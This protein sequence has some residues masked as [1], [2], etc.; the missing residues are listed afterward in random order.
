MTFWTTFFVSL[1][2]RF[3]RMSYLIL[4]TASQATVSQLLSLIDLRRTTEV[5]ISRLQEQARLTNL[6]VQQ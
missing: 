2:V 1:P 6:A 5:V 3:S 4:Y